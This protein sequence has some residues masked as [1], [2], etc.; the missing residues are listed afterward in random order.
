[1]VHINQTLSKFKK[2]VALAKFLYSRNVYQDKIVWRMLLKQ[3]LKENDIFPIEYD[4]NG[5]A[6]AKSLVEFERTMEQFSTR[7]VPMHKVMQLKDMSNIITLSYK[8]ALVDA[9]ICLR[10]IK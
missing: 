7:L 4:S 6:T 1:M 9:Y 2:Q 3:Y 8:S 10:K 5:N